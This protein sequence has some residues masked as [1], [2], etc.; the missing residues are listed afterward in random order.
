LDSWATR[1]AMQPVGN[2]WK[3]CAVKN[4]LVMLQLYRP[5]RF[6]TIHMNQVR[7][8]SSDRRNSSL[9]WLNFLIKTQTGSSVS[10]LVSSVYWNANKTRFFRF[11]VHL[12][13]MPFTIIAYNR[14]RRNIL[15]LKWYDPA[16]DYFWNSKTESSVSVNVCS[17]EC[18]FKLM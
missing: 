6:W 12:N 10:T 3:Q 2:H 7:L 13:I 16:S 1:S 17:R 11:Y 9:N 8:L 5:S 4:N 15:I 18:A 14:I